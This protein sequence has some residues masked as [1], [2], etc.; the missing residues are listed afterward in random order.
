MVSAATSNNKL[1]TQ[2]KVD[3]FLDGVGDA[4]ASEVMDNVKN[5]LC[6]NA[7]L[8]TNGVDETIGTYWT[9]PNSTRGC[10]A[11]YFQDGNIVSSL[12]LNDI[13]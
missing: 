10:G 3:E 4:S 2:E 11:T 13:N 8:I 12:C 9:G 5:L 1:P 7:D 6:A